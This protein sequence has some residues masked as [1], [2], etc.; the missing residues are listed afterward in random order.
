MKKIAIKKTERRH[1]CF[2]SESRKRYGRIHLPVAQNCNIQCVYCRRDHECLHEN[3]PGVSNGVVGPEE[4]LDRLDR[5]LEKMPEIA[6]AGIAGPGDAFCDPRP[7]LRTFELIRRKYPGMELCV[8]SN[9]LNVRDHIPDLADLNVGFVTLTINAIDPGVG[10]RLCVSVREGKGRAL[11][12]IPAARAL[13][14]RQ[15]ETVSLLKA[16]GFRV[17][18]NTVV[19]PGVNEDHAVFIAG[20]MGAM[21]VDLMNLLPLIPVPG[22]KMEG[23]EPPSRAEMRKLRRMAG[24][25]LPQMRHC[26]RCRADAAGCLDKSPDT[27]APLKTD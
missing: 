9:G 27:P 17:K 18:V 10:S 7:T 3:R 22:T 15:L 25:F 16:G 26:Q 24:K 4:A 20:K 1:P 8:S 12:G 11:S 14:A 2:F 21:G 5:A 19:V 6:V 23:A 13:I